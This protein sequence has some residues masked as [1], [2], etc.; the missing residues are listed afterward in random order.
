M[1]DMQ[2]IQQTEAAAVQ[3]KDELQELTFATLDFLQAILGHITGGNVSKET[4]L[5]ALTEAAW[6]VT[7]LERYTRGTHAENAELRRQR[8]EAVAAANVAAQ[9]RDEANHRSDELFME[10]EDAR[11]D[12]HNAEER[13]KFIMAQTIRRIEPRITQFSAQSLT[14]A[15]VNDDLDR[16]PHAAGV[17]AD[18][19]E[20]LSEIDDDQWED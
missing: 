20:A 13:I 16:N 1:T 3:P 9:E 8:N 2:K 7:E 5:E 15:L 6:M 19:N 17:L 4:A 14:D 11:F 10:A 12:A 18:L